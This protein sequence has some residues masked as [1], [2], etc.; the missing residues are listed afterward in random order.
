MNS[1]TLKISDY[2]IAALARCFLPLIQKFYESDEGKRVLEAYWAEKDMTSE[3]L[4]REQ[5]RD[6][7]RYANKVAGKKPPS[8]PRERKY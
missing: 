3:E 4:E 2:Q 6:R 1:N 7:E 5:V 8:K